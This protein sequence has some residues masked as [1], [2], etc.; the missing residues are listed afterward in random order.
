MLP[1]NNSI[2]NLTGYFAV[3]S[4]CFLGIFF[5]LDTQLNLV[6]LVQKWG[7][8][9]TWAIV[10]A[11]PLLVMIYVLGMFATTIAQ[12]IFSRF[13]L[14][15]N[16]EED[17][18][19]FIIAKF[20]NEVFI[21]RYF[22]LIQQQQTL[23]GGVIGFVFTAIAGFSQAK[24]PGSPHLLGYGVGFSFLIMAILAPLCSIYIAKQR[25]LLINSLRTKLK[26][27]SDEKNK[28]PIE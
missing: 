6:N 2:E 24:S 23:E 12:I 10:V 7:N 22:S 21:R 26:Y 16:S 27:D 17:E 11:I 20:N 15:H 3:G 28:S 18:D 8:S 5:F 9:T 14:F 13:K 4:L 19:V 1:I 25:R